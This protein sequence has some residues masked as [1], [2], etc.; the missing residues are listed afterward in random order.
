MSHP[1]LAGPAEF[2]HAME[3]ILAD[4]D[5][6]PVPGLSLVE[7][8][9]P[10]V[11][12]WARDADGCGLGIRLDARFTDAEAVVVVADMLQEAAIETLWRG[13][14]AAVWPPCPRHPDTHPPNPELRGGRAVWSC[15]KD[16]VEIC[17]IG[18]L[19]S[20]T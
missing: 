6:R 17:Q 4:L 2:A 13:G 19:R 11:H 10:S 12:L 9:D 7:S 18:D 20:L 1:D 14:L 5:A 16:S 3:P 8:T 15:P